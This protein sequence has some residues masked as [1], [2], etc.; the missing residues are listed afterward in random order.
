M[1]LD[2][3]TA[4]K[5]LRGAVLGTR[6][7]RD[8][9][10]LM[11][12]LSD[13]L[14]EAKRQRDQFATELA[15]ERQTAWEYVTAIEGYS[16]AAKKAEAEL[17]AAREKCERWQNRVSHLVKEDDAALAEYRAQVAKL[18]EALEWYA[19]QMC[20]LSRDYEGCGNLTE[21]ECAGCRARAVL[22]ETKGG[23]SE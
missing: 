11:Q 1:S 4:I 20:E 21:N 13:A 7:L 2:V 12:N 10:D 16:Q 6:H 17:A 14:V 22:A 9:A 19:D 8:I 23:D 5:C 15:D 3:E 18:R